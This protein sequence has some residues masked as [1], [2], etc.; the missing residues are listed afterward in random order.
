MVDFLVSAS[1]P[2]PNWF[3][4]LTKFNGGREPLFNQQWFV[5]TLVNPGLRIA[6]LMVDYPVSAGVMEVRFLRD[7]TFISKRS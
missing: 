5:Y 1:P 6:M 2:P 3:S 4:V 7:V